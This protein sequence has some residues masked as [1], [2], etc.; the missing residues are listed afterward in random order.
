[1]KKTHYELLQVL[2]TASTKIIKAA[3]L[4][5]V[6]DCHPDLNPGDI[7]ALE[8]SKALN[9]AYRTLMDPQ[10]RKKYDQSI[11]RRP[12][13]MPGGNG[14]QDFPHVNMGAYPDP[15]QMGE[16]GRELVEHAVRNAGQA[17]LGS[18]LGG[19]PPELQAMFKR[20]ME[21]KGKKA[22]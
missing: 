18:V 4:S 12:T 2:P 5:L 22:G 17:F 19:L 13:A 1:M 3:Y 14:I 10:L 7:H 8:M 15:Y 21:G 20:Y 6:K 11:K 16:A 9:E